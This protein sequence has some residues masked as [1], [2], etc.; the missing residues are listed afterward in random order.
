VSGA[1]A[2]YTR[3]LMT[4]RTHTVGLLDEQALFQGVN[5]SVA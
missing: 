3:A 4:W 1:D 2:T 5:R